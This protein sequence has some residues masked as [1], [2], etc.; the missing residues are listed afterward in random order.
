M[1]FN[2]LQE[3]FQFFIGVVDIEFVYE[4]IRAPDSADDTAITHDALDQSHMLDS[5][6]RSR[7]HL[8]CNLA[9]LALQLQG[10]YPTFQSTAP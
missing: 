8:V 4:A 1:E 2:A 3:F 9:L 10:H 5:E 6:E 7:F